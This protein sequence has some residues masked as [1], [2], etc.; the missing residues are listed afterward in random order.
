MNPSI[1]LVDDDGAIRQTL[2]NYLREENF[3]VR[4]ADGGENAL[5]EWRI[6]RPDL[7]V[8]DVRMPGINGFDLCRKIRELPGGKTVPILFLTS[9][10]D[11]ADKIAGLELGGDDYITKPFSP[12]EL[13]ARIRAALRRL[14]RTE[15]AEILKGGAVV[16]EPQKRLVTISKKE[17]SLTPKEFDILHLLLRKK[18]HVLSRGFLY[19]SLWG[20]TEDER[21]FRTVDTHIYRLR[22][23]LGKHGRCVVASGAHGYKWEDL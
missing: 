9:R 1:L 14:G 8:M 23:S 18:G 21:S 11:E 2:G 16:L 5:A 17:V 7:I 6:S 12:P 10:E 22:K 3:S 13:L 4:T 19:E 15:E 20:E